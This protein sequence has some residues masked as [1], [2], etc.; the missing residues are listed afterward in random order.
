MMKITYDELGVSDKEMLHEKL[1]PY[2]GKLSCTVLR[3]GMG[4]NVH[5]LPD[6]GLTNL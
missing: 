6:Q 5:L 4:S 2:E 1:E 3:G